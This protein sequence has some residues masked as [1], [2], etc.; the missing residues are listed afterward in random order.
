MQL[1][2][3]LARHNKRNECLVSTGVNRYCE[4]PGFVGR[5]CY[6]G[7][8]KERKEFPS[9]KRANRATERRETLS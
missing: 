4:H 9:F 7:A 8:K 6:C 3:I 1:I 2:Q 5:M